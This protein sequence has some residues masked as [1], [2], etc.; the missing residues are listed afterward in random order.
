MYKD[1]RVHVDRMVIVVIREIVVNQVIWYADLFFIFQIKNM[2]LFRVLMVY[3]EPKE[4]K[5]KLVQ[6]DHK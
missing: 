5:V 3:K 6:L 2:F 4:K 1:H